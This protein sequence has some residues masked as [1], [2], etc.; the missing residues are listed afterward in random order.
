MK[1]EVNI[2]LWHLDLSGARRARRDFDALGA[3]GEAALGEARKAAGIV[4]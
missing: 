4:I 2:I 3:G 1:Y